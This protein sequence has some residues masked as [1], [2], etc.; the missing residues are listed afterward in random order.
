MKYSRP[1]RFENFFLGAELVH[2]FK[3]GPEVGAAAAPQLKVVHGTDELVLV[4]DEDILPD[5]VVGLNQVQVHPVEEIL[6]P[7]QQG[8]GL[9]QKGPHQ[10]TGGGVAGVDD[11]GQLLDLLAL[12]GLQRLDEGQVAVDRQAVGVEVQVEL[13]RVEVDFL[14]R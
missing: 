4:L 6:P 2:V 8:V 13:V 5:G 11:Q 1:R 14:P 7:L 9:G 12:P 3:G 10:L